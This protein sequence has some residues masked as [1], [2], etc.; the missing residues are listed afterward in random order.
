MDS[1]ADE[2]HGM[3]SSKFSIFSMHA[4]VSFNNTCNSRCVLANVIP[5]TKLIQRFHI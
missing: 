3:G 4:V 5:S 1:F 2:Q